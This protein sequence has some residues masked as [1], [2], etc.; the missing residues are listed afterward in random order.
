VFVTTP[1]RWFPL[2]V[3]TLLPFVHWLPAEARDRLLPYDDVLDPLGPKAFAA[4]F[5]YSVRV[6]NT[7]MSLIAIGPT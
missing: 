4:L 5:P 3:H 7:G 6:L 1:N 2:E